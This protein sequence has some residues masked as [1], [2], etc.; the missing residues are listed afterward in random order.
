MNFQ[1]D[2]ILGRENTVWPNPFRICGVCDPLKMTL[3]SPSVKL[4]D[5]VCVSCYEAE[6]S[7]IW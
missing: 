4:C 2:P 3:I 6:P 1:E 7:V 5:R